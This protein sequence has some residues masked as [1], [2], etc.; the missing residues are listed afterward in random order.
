M[1]I[2]PN[3]TFVIF[4]IIFFILLVHYA[5]AVEFRYE[6]IDENPPNNPWVK[7]VGDL[8]QDNQPDVIVGGSKGPLVWYEYPN[9]TKHVIADGGYATVDGEAGDMDQDGDLDLVLG[10]IVWYENPLPDESALYEE[11]PVHRVADHETHDV[12]LGDLDLDGD[13][14]IVTRDQSD[15]GPKTGNEIYVWIHESDGDWS[16]TVLQCP[17]GEGIEAQD[18]NRDGRMDIVIGGIW[19]ENQQ[20]NNELHWQKHTYGDFHRSASVQVGDI[21]QD[22]RVDIVLAPAELKG[23]QHRISW[24]EAPEDP[25]Q[26]NWKEHVIE[27]PVET[28]YHSLELADFNGDGALDFV[29]AEMHQGEDPDIVFVSLNQN[30]GQEWEKHIVSKKGSHLV[31]T[32]DIDNDGD[33]DFMGA[34]HGGSYTPVELWRNQNKSSSKFGAVFPTETWQTVSPQDV[35]MDEEKLNQA[36]EYALTGDGSGYITRH[37]K[38]VMQWGDP[39]QSYDLKST[40]KSFGATALAV[41]L[42]DGVIELEDKAKTHHPNFGI[43]P[44]SNAETGWLDEI[45]IKHLAT[46]TAGFE[47]PGGYEPLLFKPGTKWH[48]SDGGPNW[49]AECLTLIYEQDLEDFMFE[50][51]FSPI[52]I[53][54]SDLRWRNNAYRA[55]EIKGVKRREFGS[56]IHANVNAM[57][58]LGYLYLREG[59]WEGKQLIPKWFTKQVQSS[60]PFMQGLPEH[61]DTH[62]GN[63]SEH[64]SLL[65]WNNA[66]GTLKNVPTDAHWTWGLYDSLIVVIPSMDIVVSRTGKSWERT[67]EEHY[68]VL[69]SFFEPIVES[70]TQ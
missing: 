42:Q 10:G 48:Y 12:E 29:T 39:K 68:D 45:T 64:Y 30:K 38:L 41:A 4:N 44:E 21:N 49:L 60:Y 28:V 3:K 33:I 20:A 56:G 24:F 40:T 25:T 70:V 32:G 14:D 62:H 54:Q 6:V 8:N 69:K 35:G 57:A 53:T 9:W 22:G 66:D 61:D 51:I 7:I 27:E 67:S 23:E 31:R 16:H 50:R 52:G 18:I 36:K 43:P 63:A 34:N 65:W 19:F 37:G 13:L 1:K 15:F 26:D 11:W 46:Q 59:R 58:R 47:K 55:H 17:H 5:E 2:S